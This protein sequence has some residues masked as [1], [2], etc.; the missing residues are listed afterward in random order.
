MT[1]GAPQRV[2]VIDDNFSIHEDFR[3]ILCPASTEAIDLARAALFREEPAAVTQ[4]RFTVDSAFQGEEGCALV[5]SALA[6]GR[7]YAVAFIDVRMPPGIDGIETAERLWQICPELQVV[8]CTAH[9]DY[10]WEEMVARLR[11]RAQLLILTKPFAPVEVLQ[12]ACALNEKWELSRQAI[13]RLEETER[14]VEERTREVR[15]TNQ[16]LVT[17][18]AQRKE[19]EQHLLRAQRLESIGTLASGIAHDLNNVLSPILLSAQLLHDEWSSPDREDLVGAIESGALRAAGIVRQVLTFARGIDGQRLPLQPKQVIQEIK[20]IIGET[21][22]RSIK[23]ECELG[24]DLWLIESDSTQMHQVLMNLCVNARDAMPTGGTLRITAGNFEAD[25]GYASMIPAA[26]AGSYV[27]LSIADTGTGMSRELI[28]KIFDPFF[29]TKAPGKGTGLG[30]STVAGIVRSHGGFIDVRSK[31]GSGTTMDIFLPAACAGASEPA[32]VEEAEPPMGNG[33]LILVVDDEADIRNTTQ[34]LLTSRGYR[35]IAAADGAEALSISAKQRNGIAAVVTDLLMPIVD[36]IA[37]CRALRKIDPEVRIVAVTGCLENAR[38]QEL[39]SLN[40]C[41]VLSKP[42]QTGVLL[43]A[44]HA[45]LSSRTKHR[46]AFDAPAGRAQTPA[47]GIQ[48]C[49]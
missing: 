22:P 37:L 4:P 10:S 16:R 2:L 19:A 45:A 5:E 42:Y 32:R 13:D 1:P 25:A 44:L 33:E 26:H 36:G 11:R 41:S 47:K 48:L 8:I 46:Q 14:T 18:I 21:F 24:K 3:K 15:E 49:A 31:I 27:R 39:L 28:D 35:V 29:T 34:A 38:T 23:I 17:E 12:L 20:T 7:P 30:L 9:S 40:L 43:A 6:E